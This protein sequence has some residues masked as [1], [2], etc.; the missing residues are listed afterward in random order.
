[1]KI[2][3]RHAE[4]GTCTTD[5]CCIIRES[6]AAKI[7][8]ILRVHPQT[9]GMQFIFIPVLHMGFTHCIF[10]AVFQFR[11]GGQKG[12]LVAYPDEDFDKICVRANPR[13]RHVKYIYAYRPSMHKYDGGPTMIEINKV[14]GP[15]RSARLNLSFIILLLTLGTK[16]EVCLVLSM[17]I[18]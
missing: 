8:N 7:R 4:D 9:A 14:S 10:G 15:P 12:L 16:L 5:G 13:A 18:E 1:M 11:R 17:S 2:P 3:D 6:E